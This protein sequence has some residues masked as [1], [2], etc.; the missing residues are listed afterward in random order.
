[1]LKRADVTLAKAIFAARLGQD[2]VYGGHWSSDPTDGTD[3]SGL[4]GEELEAATKGSAM[5]WGHP[6]STESWPPDAQP[7]D[8][9][10]YGTIN[11]ATPHD[12]PADAA[13]TVS[14]HHGGGGPDS[15]MNITL[16]STVMEDSGDHGVCTVAGGA[17]PATDPYWNQWWYIPGP[18]LDTSR[19]VDFAG[20]RPGGQAIAEMGYRFVCRYLSDGGTELPS[21][22]LTVD[23]ARDLGAHGLGVV[24]NWE[25]TADRMLGGYNAGV[26]DSLLAD[27]WHTRCGGPPGRPIYFSADWDATPEQQN[28]INDYL[29]GCASIIGLSR[30]G[31]YGGY[32]PVARALDAGLCAWSWQATAWSATNI[33]SRINI[34]QRSGEFTTIGGVQCDINDSYTADYGQWNYQAAEDD[35]MSA[36]DSQF[37]ADIHAA[38]FNDIQSRSPFRHLGEGAVLESYELPVNDDGFAHAQYV[39]WA[40]GRG[41]TDA[42]GLLREIAGANPSQY[43]DRAA[44]IRLAQ[45]VLGRLGGA[46]P[47]SQPVPYIAPPVV[48]PP[49]AALKVTSNPLRMQPVQYAKAIVAFLGGV[50]TFATA[51]QSLLGQFLPGHW[52]EVLSATI[53]AFTGISVFVVKNE[54]LIESL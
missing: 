1:M 22:R 54:T 6:V 25:N 7:G 48:A 27:A 19:G 8:S 21:K 40:A 16:D 4:A 28:L 43:P 49:V 33:D 35:P 38:M 20:G 45:T 24:S 12:V 2:Y 52:N 44:D 31:I 32:W 36:Q 50:I 26:D 34:L 3:C 42:L 11:A 13:A 23:E 15:H 9:G 46:A 17:M 53:A 37:L 18:I 5:I 39:E 14:I 29:R 30:V 47:A 41:D 51:S 10:P